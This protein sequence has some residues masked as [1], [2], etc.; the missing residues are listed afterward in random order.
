MYFSKLIKFLVIILA[1]DI[2]AQY[3]NSNGEVFSEARNG[4]HQMIEKTENGSHQMIQK[5]EN[6][7]EYGSEK[8]AKRVGPPAHAILSSTNGTSQR[9]YC[10]FFWPNLTPLPY[11]SN[12]V[13]S[14][15]IL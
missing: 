7:S 15:L 1:I 2:S 13:S 6:S 9:N 11:Q 12:I 8:G 14:T 4:S 10:I 3:E 5:A